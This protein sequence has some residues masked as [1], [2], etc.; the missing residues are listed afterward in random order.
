LPLSISLST[1]LRLLTS[2]NPEG[3]YLKIFTLSLVARH[4]ASFSCWS[5]C[6]RVPASL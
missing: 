4:N 3:I 6:G 5:G 1:K 2:I